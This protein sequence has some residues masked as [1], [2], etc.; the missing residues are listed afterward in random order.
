[1]SWRTRR[2]EAML[3][4]LLL[5]LTRKGGQTTHGHP[6]VLVSMRSLHTARVPVDIPV[7]LLM[8]LCA[9]AERRCRGRVVV[10]GARALARSSEPACA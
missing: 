1:M 3:L 5:L 9:R 10:Q 2:L 7:L 8:L 6:P 4:L